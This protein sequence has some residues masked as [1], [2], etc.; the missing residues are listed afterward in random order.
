MAKKIDTTNLT[1]KLATLRG[2]DF[3]QAEAE[4]RGAGNAAIE[5]TFSKSF[6]ARLAAKALG[7]NVNDIKALPLAKYYS[8][9]AEVSRFL[10]SS[11][12]SVEMDLDKFDASLSD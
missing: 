6:Q 12:V 8:I 10:F 4:E 9:T 5:M 1:E 11:S 3:E 2:L 7:V